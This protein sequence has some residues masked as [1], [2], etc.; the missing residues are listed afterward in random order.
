MKGGLTLEQGFA[1]AFIICLP[2]RMLTILTPIKDIM[3]AQAEYFSLIFHALGIMLC[4]SNPKVLFGDGHRGPG[5]LISVYW[6]MVA[7]FAATS[8]MM[9]IYVNSTFGKF[10]GNSP[11]IA[12]LKMALDFV[13]YGLIMMYSKAAFGLIGR[14]SVLKCLLLATRITLFVGYLQIAV[15]ANIP[16]ITGF[17]NALA[18]I[19]SF[20]TFRR[21]IALT[22]WEPSWAAM[23]IGIVVIPLHAAR[24]ITRCDSPTA[25]VGEFLAWI[26]V[27]IFTKS[28]TAY[29]LSFA[30]LGTAILFILFGRTRNFGAR[31]LA[32][33]LMG[34]GIFMLNNLEYMDSVLGFNF[35]YL[36]RTKVFDMQNQSTASRMIPIIGNWAIFLKFPLIGCGNGLQGYYFKSLI[37]GIASNFRAL[38]KASQTLLSGTLPDIAN[39]QLFFPGVLSG[40][41]LLGS[42]LLIRFFAKCLKCVRE[43]AE[44]FGIFGQIYL[45]AFVPMFIAGFKSEFV[46]IYYLWFILS[47]PYAAYDAELDY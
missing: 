18:K 31:L 14:E 26:P 30:S 7:V 35:S 46:G 21:Q 29:L 17:Y 32:V 19:F 22:F 34:A 12:V 2:L 39:G 5:T 10:N 20:N 42:A 43:R 15:L 16:V 9:A 38:D 36:L 37:G 6:K 28:T 25:V 45:I 13:Q 44:S 1:K 41:G 33:L 27:I 4:L 23:F 11:Y 24:L 40:Y 47:L 3:G 8:F